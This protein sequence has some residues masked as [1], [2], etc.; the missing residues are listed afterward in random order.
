MPMIMIALQE[1]GYED[2][3]PP[4]TPNEQL[5]QGFPSL[6]P[7]P[8]GFE[9]QNMEEHEDQGPAVPRFV[10]DSDQFGEDPQ[11]S[12]RFMS[13]WGECRC[14]EKTLYQHLPAPERAWR[15]TAKNAF[16]ANQLGEDAHDSASEDR[17]T[18]AP[19]LK[20][21]CVPHK[22]PTLLLKCFPDCC[23]RVVGATGSGKSS[24]SRALTSNDLK[25]T[26]LPPVHK[27]RKRFELT[28]RNRLGVMY[29]RRPSRGRIHSRRMGGDP[30][31]HP[32]I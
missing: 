13:S 26:Q 31:R 8:R 28:G 25:L 10:F 4:D 23:H 9:G 1:C 2:G 3:V 27:S 19:S 17:S 21:A 15:D 16:V 32:G 12:T 5:R 14:P 29:D 30:H 24:V 11:H 18:P 20:I 7:D 6:H 22:Q